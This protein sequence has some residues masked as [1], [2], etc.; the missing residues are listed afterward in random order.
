MQGPSVTPLELR[1]IGKRFG[2]L[3]VLRGVDLRV[4]AGEVVGLIG[5]NG[6]GK[7]TLLSIAVGLMS[8]S[9]GER[10]L[11]GELA[12]Q[13][14]LAQRARIAFV[15]HTTQLYPRLSARENMALFAELRRAAG[16]DAAPADP[17]LE[18]L[19]L[20]DAADRL[21]GTFSRGM[22]QRLALARALLGRPSLLLL[23]EPFT[24]LD[25]PGRDRLTEVLADER[26]AGLAVLLSS[27][28]YDAVV[29]STD[30]VVLLEGGRLRGE[31]R[32]DEGE[33]G[34]YRDRVAALGRPDR[35][36]A[37]TEAGAHA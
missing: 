11:G 22:M 12:P 7:T 37:A 18:R 28:D 10:R 24:S 31:A 5:A 4:D 23:D 9:E 14:E 27:H 17:L 35:L 6:S 19:G 33:A 15:A 29:A 26:A 20:A 30:R 1:G 3:A 2:R 36:A 32:R 16:L 8:P 25:R 13:V 34:S 21:V